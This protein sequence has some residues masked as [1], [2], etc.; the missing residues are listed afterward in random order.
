MARTST[1]SFF[2]GSGFVGFCV[3]A[4]K[5]FD[6]VAPVRYGTVMIPSVFGLGVVD[7]FHFVA[8]SAAYRGN[9]ADLAVRAR[10]LR[11]RTRFGFIFVARATIAYRHFVKRQGLPSALSDNHNQNS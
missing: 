4:Q 1:D 2:V 10:A 8:Q 6:R 3:F 7:A 9:D 11:T 5:H